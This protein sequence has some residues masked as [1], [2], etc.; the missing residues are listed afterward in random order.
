M[1]PPAPVTNAQGFIA[2]DILSSPS[3]TFDVHTGHVTAEGGGLK[4]QERVAQRQE[5]VARLVKV[6]VRQ[7]TGRHCA[8]GNAELGPDVLTRFACLPSDERRLSSTHELNPA[9]R[10]AQAAE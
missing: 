9:L 5:G 6:V 4:R 10:T 2:F 3:Q 8:N 7:T 1:K